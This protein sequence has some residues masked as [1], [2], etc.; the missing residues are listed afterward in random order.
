MC[1]FPT[2]TE[3]TI[4]LNVTGYNKPLLDIVRKKKEEKKLLDWVNRPWSK[5]CCTRTLIIM[6]H[7]Q[8]IPWKITSTCAKTEN[9]TIF[10]IIILYLSANP[11]SICKWT[12]AK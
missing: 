6:L 2:L 9:I 11:V 8:N 1:K 3:D 7:T 4:L 10:L 5:P 12:S